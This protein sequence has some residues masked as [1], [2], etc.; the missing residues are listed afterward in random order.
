MVGRDQIVGF[1]VTQ[2]FEHGMRRRIE[3]SRPTYQR[4]DQRS[5]SVQD[6]ARGYPRGDALGISIKLWNTGLPS[7]GEV[8]TAFLHQLIE[9]H[10]QLG[11]LLAIGIQALSPV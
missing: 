7:V 8:A 3:I 11:M 5:D 4:R 1:E 9:C 10:C 6:L 2:A